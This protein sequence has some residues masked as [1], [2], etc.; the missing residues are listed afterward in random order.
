L[1]VVGVATCAGLPP[2]L[3][4]TTG[5]VEVDPLGVVV[6]LLFALRVLEVLALLLG[7]ATPT[8]AGLAGAFG[9][10]VVG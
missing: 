1:V 5:V 9:E 2:G 6:V 10:V 4:E 8:L 7:G 3:V